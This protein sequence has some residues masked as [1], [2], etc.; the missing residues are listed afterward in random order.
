MVERSK[1]I[2]LIGDELDYNPKF[3]QWLKDQGLWDRGL[4]YRFV[5]VIGCQSSGKSTLLNLLFDTKF[6]VM[7]EDDGRN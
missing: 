1:E 6:D 5:A 2:Q 3:E 7:N 4:D